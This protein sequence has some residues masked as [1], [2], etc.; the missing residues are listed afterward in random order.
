[1][2]STPENAVEILRSID[3]SRADDNQAWQSICIALK[4]LGVPYEVFEAWSLTGRH[5]DRQQIRR[6]WANLRGNHSMGT[7]CY[8][9]KRDAGRL[10][11]IQQRPQGKFDG[12]RAWE[13]IIQPYITVPDLEGELWER[14]PYRMDFECG[15]ED[16]EALLSTLYEPDDLI[17]IGESCANFQRQRECVR[18]VTEHLSDLRLAE[19]FRPNPLTG[20]PVCRENGRQSL[21]CDECVAKFR[22]AVVEFDAKPLTE[23][24]AFYLAMLDMGMPFAALIHSGNKSVHGLLAVNCPDADTWTRKVENKLFRSNLELLGCDGACKNESRMTRTPGAMR[25]NGKMQK[26]LYLNPNL[27]G[28]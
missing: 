18:T 2:D 12:R 28:N 7:L 9:A 14:S 23:Q 10:P 15:H 3:R 24:Y 5:H 17:F 20:I 22:F 27:K 8:Y 13:S 16:M 26:L 4:N 21:V 6:A 1:M 11:V 19:Y 25:S